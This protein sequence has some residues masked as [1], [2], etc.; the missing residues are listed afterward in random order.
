MKDFADYGP[1]PISACWTFLR[2]P[3]NMMEVTYGLAHAKSMDEFKSY[4][5]KL[6]APGLNVL[7]A[8]RE[9]NIAWWAVAKIVKRPEHAQ[10]SFVV[11]GST[12][13]NDWLGYYDFELNPSSVKS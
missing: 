8:D 11:D 12:G 10:T 4:L 2:E 9:N 3:N 7:Y 6:A 13:D 5:P 1:D